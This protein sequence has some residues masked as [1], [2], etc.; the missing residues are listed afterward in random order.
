MKPVNFGGDGGTPTRSPG[1]GMSVGIGAGMVFGL[2]IGIALDA[3]ALGIVLGCALGVT[4]GAAMEAGSS[5]AAAYTDDRM[6]LFVGLGLA[7]LAILA[8]IL[9]ALLLRNS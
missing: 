9:F 4:L 8:V 6:N 3:I 2:L 1:S 7:A 5:D